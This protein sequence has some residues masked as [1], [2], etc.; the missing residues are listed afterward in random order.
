M[1][2]GEQLSEEEVS[3]IS[4]L[5]LAFVGDSVHT[6]YVRSSIVGSGGHRVGDYHSKSASF[7]KASSQAKALDAVVENLSEKE[8]DIVRRARNAKSHN[9]AKNSDIATYKKATSFEALVGYLY[10]TNQHKRMN[11]ILDASMN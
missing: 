1:F 4:P 6:L 7:C 8:G 2:F 10:L 11:E 9:I 5:V 3:Q